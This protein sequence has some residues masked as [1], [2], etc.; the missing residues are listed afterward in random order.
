MN[1]MAFYLGALALGGFSVILIRS[2][3][4]YSLS[5]C[6]VYERKRNR[7]LIGVILLV[8]ATLFLGIGGLAQFVSSNP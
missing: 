2:A 6:S 5:G 8:V 4:P 1:T 3:S 7:R